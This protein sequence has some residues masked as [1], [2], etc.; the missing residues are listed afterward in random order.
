M[1]IPRFLDLVKEGRM[2]DAF[3][4]VILDNPLPASTGRVCQHPCDNR[5]RRQATDTAVNMREVHRF[6]ADTVL[7]SDDFE[8]IAG[9][10]ASRKMAPTGK[11]VAVAGAGPSGLT[12]AFYLALLGHEVSV[13]ESKPEAGG[14]LRYA[15][16]EY[17]LPKRVLAR[18]VDLIRRLGVQFHFGAAVGSAIT[19]KELDEQFDAVFL[20]IGTWKESWVYLAGTELK[21][22]IPAL[23]FLEGIASGETTSTG[24]RVVVIGGG[25]AAVDS[26][27]SAVRMGAQATIL[28]RRQR[29]DMPAIKEEVDAAEQ[30]GVRLQFLSTPHRIL[31]DA[32]GEVKGIE[33]EKTRL[34]EY[35]HSGRRK[36]VST[37]EVVRMDCDAVVLAVGETV[38]MDFARASGLTLAEAGTFVV[39]RYSLETS[40]PKFY[41]GGDVI[42]G[43]SN[44]SNAMGYGKKAARKM[45]EML[46][47]AKRFALLFGGFEY[48]QLAPEVPSTSPRHR[49]AELSALVRIKSEDEV[50]LGLTP[51]QA[52]D[53]ACRCLR[54][55]VRG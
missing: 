29:K 9:R 44:V 51:E 28:Y 8:T 27:R 24:R 11:R 1:N 14:M 23:P 25:N 38:D 43:A 55:D 17:R 40:R 10:F 22:V 34:G 31:G 39:D 19:L 32:H 26:A 15:I 6:I 20:S 49:S 2:A 18:E 46:M 21:G 4:S 52:N 3:E 47:G 54:C 50:V 37:G 42:T 12:C 36:P 7:L 30:E 16:P 53:E 5:C 33:I 48:S 13:F 45:D 41:A 35:D